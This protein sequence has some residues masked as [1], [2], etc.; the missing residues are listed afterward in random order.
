MDNPIIDEVRRA[1][2]EHARKFNYDLAA[3]CAD[4]RK[5]QKTCGH[6][7]VTLKQSRSKDKY[8]ETETEIMA[9]RENSDDVH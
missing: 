2:E 5:H 3:I 4:I 7:V 9:C 1:R 8:P 6:P